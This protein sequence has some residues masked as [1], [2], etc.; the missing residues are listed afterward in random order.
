M[1]G[2][3]VRA[4]NEVVG[5]NKNLLTLFLMN[6]SVGEVDLLMVEMAN[7]YETSGRGS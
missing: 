3:I 5:H 6:A 1:V 7:Q 4:I 2:P